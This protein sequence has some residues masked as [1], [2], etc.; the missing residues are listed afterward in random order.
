MMQE[1]QR[2]ADEQSTR[3]KLAAFGA[4]VLKQHREDSGCDLYGDD[5]EELASKHGL[6]E[7]RAVAGACGDDCTCALYAD[8]PTECLFVPDDVAALMRAS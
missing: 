8:F 1:I 2:L 5:I 6:L 7:R 3:S 4:A